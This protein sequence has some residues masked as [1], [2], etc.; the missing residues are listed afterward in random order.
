M[1]PDPKKLRA[2]LDDVLPPSGESCGP[3]S[4]EVLDLLRSERRRRG[5][6]RTSNAV[7]VIIVLVAGMWLWQSDRPAPAP[8]ILATA[9]HAPLTI[10][11]V[12]DE[13]L[14]ALFQG[15]PAAL[16]KWPNGDRTLFVVDHGTSP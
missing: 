14:L 6:L 3:S 15:T 9:Q 10:K 11:D 2:L 8:V 5:R 7:L 16:L 4:A 12:N 1:K 13:E